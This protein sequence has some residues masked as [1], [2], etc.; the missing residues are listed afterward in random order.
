[1]RL[2]LRTYG[3]QAT[4][5]YRFGR[6]LAQLATSP[7]GRVIALCLWAPY[8][9]AN[10]SVRK[11][12]GIDLALSAHIGPGLYIGHFGGIK[13]ANC[14]LGPS[15][16]IAQHTVIGDAHSNERPVIGARV[17]IGAHARI[18]GA[19][20]VGDGATISAGAKVRGD[21]APRTLVMGDPART[22]SRNY[23]NASL[24]LLDVGAMDACTQQPDQ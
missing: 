19:I 15:C 24:L 8:A 2:V 10:W 23:D 11:S 21:V 18:L 5:V 6:S 7:A 9:I 14:E 17:W 4:L 1:L 22:V 16:S 20:T 3:L 13:I 12:Y